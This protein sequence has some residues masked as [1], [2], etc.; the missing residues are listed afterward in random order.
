MAAEVS[1]MLY[2]SRGW[3]R[4]SWDS[5][6]RVTAKD[7]RVVGRKAKQKVRYQSIMSTDYFSIYLRRV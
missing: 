1:G 4:N 3:A 2:K 5:K 7:T 6:A